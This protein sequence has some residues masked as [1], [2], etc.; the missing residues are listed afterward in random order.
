M[1]REQQAACFEQSRRKIVQSCAR[2][3]NDLNKCVENTDTFC[4]PGRLNIRM[5]GSNALARVGHLYLYSLL[6][7][8][9][10][11]EIG[12]IYKHYRRRARECH[13]DK[14]QGMAFLSIKN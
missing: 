2:Y 6:G 3:K 8:D 1:L 4:F 10:Q 12:T 13:P 5:G 9:E 7:V 11:A 14:K